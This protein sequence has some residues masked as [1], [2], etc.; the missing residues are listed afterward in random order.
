MLFLFSGPVY[1]GLYY[2]L[3]TCIY[4]LFINVFIRSNIICIDALWLTK[5]HYNM[6]GHSMQFSYVSVNCHLLACCRDCLDMLCLYLRCGLKDDQS[7]SRVYIHSIFK[8]TP[9]YLGK[10]LDSGISQDWKC[11]HFSET[12]CCREGGFGDWTGAHGLERSKKSKAALWANTYNQLCCISRF[13]SGRLWPK[14]GEPGFSHCRFW[15]VLEVL[16]V[17]VFVWWSMG[18]QLLVSL[19][20][21]AE[22][23]R[24]RECVE[25]FEIGWNW[26]KMDKFRIR[27]E[28]FEL[29][30]KTLAFPCSSYNHEANARKWSQSGGVI[31]RPWRMFVERR[32][33]WLCWIV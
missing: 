27:F 19:I 4:R 15:M 30:T 8:S 11:D 6:N 1:V 18:W 33:W 21:V 22:P 17:L 9:N 20:S 14:S 31:Q 29:C 10:R 32:V 5:V 23:P 3:L 24:P 16:E 2:F 25:M 7:K 28:L 12:R 13:D 26:A